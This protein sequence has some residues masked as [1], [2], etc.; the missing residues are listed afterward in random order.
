MKTDDSEDIDLSEL[1]AIKAVRDELTVHSDN[2]LLRNH[3]IVLPKSLRQRSIDIAH[4]G[5]QG[6][7][8][9]KSFTRTKVWFPGMDGMIEEA[10]KNCASCQT[11]TPE[12]RSVEPYKMSEL[13]SGPWENISIDFCGPLPSSDYLFV[14]VDEYSRYP[15]VEI[16]KSVSA[17]S[18][19]PVLDK[20]ISTFELPKTVK[21]DN[22][23][24]FQSYEFKQFVENMGFVHRRITPRWP[25][26]N[27]QAE[28]FNK[29][30]MKAIR[31][32]HINQQNW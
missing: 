13:P 4:E 25:R 6:V 2:I 27:A 14:M 12:F 5:H 20:V 10:V 19:I 31:S 7:A 1:T 11:L 26:A 9:T 16:V 22:G 21:S 23:S 30:L 18:T 24:Q 8:K 32:A 3:R 29:P 15:I 17:R 28:S